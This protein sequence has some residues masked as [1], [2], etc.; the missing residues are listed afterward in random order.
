MRRFPR[1]AQQHVFRHILRPERHWFAKDNWLN[2]ARTQM[3]GDRQSIWAGTYDGGFDF[4]RHPRTP[5]KLIEMIALLTER[6]PLSP[7]HLSTALYTADPLITLAL[8]KPA[9]QERTSPGHA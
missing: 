8:R 4:P 3:S 9:L 2:A 5:Q 6:L 7:L 1:R